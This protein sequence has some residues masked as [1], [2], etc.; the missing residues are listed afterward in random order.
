LELH[1]ERKHLAENVNHLYSVFDM[2][3]TEK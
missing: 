2:S 1:Y 3:I